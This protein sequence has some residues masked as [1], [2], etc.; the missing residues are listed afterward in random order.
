MTFTFESIV[1]LFRARSTLIT[2]KEAHDLADE[3]L[4]MHSERVCVVENNARDAGKLEGYEKGYKAGKMDSE[5]YDRG[6]IDGRKTAQGVATIDQFELSRLQTIEGKM[7]KLAYVPAHELVDAYP[8]RKIK[9]IRE[10]VD[11]TGLSVSLCKEIVD[12]VHKK[13]HG[14]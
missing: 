4:S 13:V 14:K 6:Y 2:L 5:E 11:I 8:G 9:C 3:L 7:Y 12:E 10:L 1:R